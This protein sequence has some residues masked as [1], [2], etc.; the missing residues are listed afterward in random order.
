[1]ASLPTTF[2]PLAFAAGLVVGLFVDAIGTSGR[3]NILAPPLL[4]LLA[5]NIAVYLMLVGSQIGL[6]AGAAKGMA[7][8]LRRALARGLERLGVDQQ[9]L[10]GA[11]VAAVLHAGAAAFA[12]GA[13]AAMYLR[14]VAF[15]YR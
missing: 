3:I 13:L 2:T 14:G 5:W 12:I 10:D 6:G 8:P 4:G 11:Q 9:Q 1:M 15:E 7:R